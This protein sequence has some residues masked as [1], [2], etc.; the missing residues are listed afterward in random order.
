MDRLLWYLESNGM[1]MMIAIII[2]IGVLVEKDKQERQRIFF[3]LCLACIVSSITDTLWMAL[4]MGVITWQ[5]RLVNCILNILNLGSIYVSIFLWWVYAELSM[6]QPRLENRKFRLLVSLPIIGLMVM[7][8]SSPVTGWLFVID[9][10]GAYS[11]GAL[12]SVAVVVTYGYMLV[13]SGHALFLAKKCYNEVKRKEYFVIAAFVIPPIACNVIQ[14][15]FYGTPLSTLGF[16][17]SMLMV[18]TV[19]QSHKVQMD[20]LTQ[21]NNRNRLYPYL[22][23]ELNNYDGSRMLYAVGI[24]ADMIKS[25]DENGNATKAS[26]DD[27]ITFMA[28]ALRDVGNKYPCFIA[29]MDGEAFCIIYKCDSE[30]D[31]ESF[32]FDLK[33]TI[34]DARLKHK[35]PYMLK[36]AIGY[37]AYNPKTMGKDI[38]ALINAADASMMASRRG[39]A[40]I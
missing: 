7:L 24:E 9:E 18:F 25:I 20:T 4:E 5:V 34:S 11:R 13:T 16:T 37:A 36:A 1:C 17:L 28:E 29:R 35:L 8:F 10:N 19:M 40:H 38:K 3:W 21:L 31:I 12:L 39:G 23:E 26:S 6:E 2:A 32:V 22:E 30:D 27:I 14:L 33:A 15:M